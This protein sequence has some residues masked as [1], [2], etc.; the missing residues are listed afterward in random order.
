[1]LISIIIPVYNAE[2]F[3]PKCLDSVK[4]QTYKN[5]EIILVNDGSTDMSGLICDEYSQK[6]NRFI[7]LHKE[8]GGVSSARNTGLEIAKGDYIGFVDPDDWIEPDMYEKLYQLIIEFQ[9]DISSCGYFTENVYGKVRYHTTKSDIIKFN[10]V[11]A[12][13]TILD[14]NSFRG[15]TCNKLFSADLI[16]KAPVVNFDY[17][18]HFGE[19]LL[20][21]CEMILKSKNIVYSPTPYY[22]YITHDSNATIQKYGSKKLTFL[23][24]FEKIIDLLST[25]EGVDLKKY[26]TFYMHT[27]I[28][29]LMHGIKEKK[30]TESIRKHLKQNLYRYKLT[31]FNGRSIKLSCLIARVNINLC[32]FLWRNKM[33]LLN[34]TGNNSSLNPQNG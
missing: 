17:D 3:L 21:C 23:N 8:N 28:S 10:R 9:A 16:K 25:V 20:F 33:I 6:D 14:M 31:D 30:I 2:K 18:I 34:K 19:D 13:N 26:K 1:M 24:A 29:L 11:T 7:V 5:L 32:Y 12:L 22:H 15:I 27:N 4:N